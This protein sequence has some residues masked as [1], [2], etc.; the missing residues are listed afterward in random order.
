MELPLNHAWALTLVGQAGRRR[1]SELFEP[2]CL[3][4]HGGRGAQPVAERRRTRPC[5]RQHD[6]GD[7]RLRGRYCAAAP[8]PLAVRMYHSR[9]RKERLDCPL[10]PFGLLSMEV[11]NDDTALEP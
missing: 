2:G 1:G 7:H 10:D 8:G 4:R 5:G 6:V 3:A 9:S 11:M